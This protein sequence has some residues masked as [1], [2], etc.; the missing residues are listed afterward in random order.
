MGTEYAGGYGFPDEYY[1]DDVFTSAAR[2]RAAER[3][4]YFA[5]ELENLTKSTKA[6]E[7][8][9][10]REYNW[11]VALE[12][13]KKSIALVEAASQELMLLGADA[14][15][16]CARDR[17]IVKKWGGKGPI[18]AVFGMLGGGLVLGVAG[19]VLIAPACALFILGGIAGGCFIGKKIEQAGA[20]WDRLNL[21]A[22]KLEAT[23]TA[24]PVKEPLKLLEGS[25]EGED[26]QRNLDDSN[27]LR[28]SY[29]DTYNTQIESAY[30][31]RSFTEVD[32]ASK[33]FDGVLR[34][35]RA[36]QLAP[37]KPDARRNVPFP[38]P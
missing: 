24:F 29:I 38:M 37:G 7:Q 4:N 28:E 20:A 18:A 14:A 8:A 23:H 2:R 32:V 30:L 16:A 1:P 33:D 31:T 15:K 25:R 10:K 22:M 19:A 6:R 27:P 11:T 34:E 36:A 9:A 3:E 17:A 5:D 12:N 13:A 26:E 35:A 21:S